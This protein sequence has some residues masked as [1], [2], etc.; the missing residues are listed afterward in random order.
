MNPAIRRT[1]S[2]FSQIAY[3]THSMKRKRHS[4]PSTLSHFI[5]LLF[6][7]FVVMGC[8]PAVSQT[9]TPFALASSPTPNIAGAR[10]LRLTLEDVLFNPVA[11]E[12]ARIQVNGR[13]KK[14]PVRVCEGQ[15]FDSPASWSITDGERILFLD[16]F[17]GQIRQLLPEQITVEVSGIWRRWNGPM[18]CGKEAIRSEVFYLDVRNVISPNPITAVTLTPFGEAIAEDPLTTP[19]SVADEAAPTPDDREEDAPPDVVILPTASSTP[20]SSSPSNG[21]APSLTPTIDDSGDEDDGSGED[22][23]VNPTGTGTATQTA[24]P[25]GS[26]PT[27]TPGGAAP[28]A[29]PTGAVPPTLSPNVTTLDQGALSDAEFGFETL[30]NNT[31]HSWAVSLDVG[32]LITITTVMEID[33]NPVLTLKSPMGDTLFDRQNSG[34]VGEPEIIAAYEVPSAG[35]YTIEVRAASLQTT[36]YVI[37]YY[38]EGVPPAFKFWP[39]LDD[40]ETFSG[41]TVE[42][43][44]DHIWPVFASAG[45]TI[46]FGVTPQGD[47]DFF[48]TLFG[49]DG[50]EDES[51]D[52]N[53]GATEAIT[54]DVQETGLYLLQVG[55]WDWLRR[56]Y[57]L[58]FSRD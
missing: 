34:G 45:E 25:S 39:I 4:S 32:D 16:G 5:L 55:D 29:T 43:E 12:G 9:P 48:I 22:P 13:Y 56:T 26:T 58:T 49:K 23:G 11:Y 57:Q 35:V 54:Y 31:A 27:P 14:L 1:H 21:N 42:A 40:S 37:N 44:T 46:S 50:Q 28:T 8:T 18:G 47:A 53:L 41:V 2:L 3:N 33:K 7:F 15:R 6:T 19:E 30:P 24:V 17:E 10:P 38:V 36:H 20:T 52:E 51:D